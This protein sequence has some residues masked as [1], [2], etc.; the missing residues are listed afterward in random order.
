MTLFQIICLV[1]VTVH[2]GTIILKTAVEDDK[3]TQSFEPESLPGGTAFTFW[4]CSV[5]LEAILAQNLASL[6][7]LELPFLGLYNNAIQPDNFQYHF[8]EK[9][10]IPNVTQN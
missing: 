1:Q 6:Y 10:F 9:S 7:H 2:Q 3:L 8:V 4:E 5:P